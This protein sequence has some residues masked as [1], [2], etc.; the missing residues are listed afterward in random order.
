MP[1]PEYAKLVD[2]ALEA[3][4]RARE[5]RSSDA[6]MREAA[7]SLAASFAYLAASDRDRTIEL[8]REEQERDAR[9]ARDEAL[10]RNCRYRQHER[11]CAA[12]GTTFEP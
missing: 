4:A 10:C 1:T 9:N 11:D 5:T 7:V 8:D 2:T 3:V 12:C 6:A